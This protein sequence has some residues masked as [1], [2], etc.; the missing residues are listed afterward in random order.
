MNICI[1]N[2]VSLFFL[3]INLSNWTKTKSYCKTVQF[4]TI[5]IFVY[6]FHNCPHVYREMNPTNLVFALCLTFVGYTAQAMGT[7]IYTNF[8][9]LIK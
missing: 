6:F 8:V 1:F 4:S 3:L 7:T 9:R 5:E 2:T